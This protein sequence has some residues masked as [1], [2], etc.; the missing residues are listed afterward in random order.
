MANEF[1]GNTHKGPERRKARRIK[2]RFII[3]YKLVYPIEIKMWI[4]GR[5]VNALMLDLS[6][7]GMAILTKYDLPALTRLSINFTL[8]NP[9]VEKENR[10]KAMEIEGEVKNN[11]LLEK[12]EHRLGFVF[13]QITEKDKS[14]IVNFVKMKPE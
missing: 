6:P 5:E 11:I 4:G 2:V 9:Y 13:T 12:D 8:I 1:M 7:M 3:T 14:E 10:I